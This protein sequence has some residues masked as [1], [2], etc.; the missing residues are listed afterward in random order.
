MTEQ[1]ANLLRASSENMSKLENKIAAEKTRSE[2]LRKLLKEQKSEH[3][4]EIDGMKYK[5]WYYEIFCFCQSS[6]SFSLS[7][8]FSSAF[9]SHLFFL[10]NETK[11][12]GFLKQLFFV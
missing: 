4:V 3:Q 10:F 7:F 9:F 12:L 11:I 8:R 2:E 1:L 5:I 6:I